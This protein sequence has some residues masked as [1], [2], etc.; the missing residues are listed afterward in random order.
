MKTS[1]LIQLMQASFFGCVLFL[2]SLGLEIHLY[3]YYSLI[4]IAC[5][6]GFYL[7]LG[8]KEN[9]IYIPR[10]I[11]WYSVFMFSLSSLLF[12]IIHADLLS[13]ARSILV[14][15]SFLLCFN[16]IKNNIK[17]T[18]YFMIFSTLFA[19]IAYGLHF[20]NGHFI[21]WEYQHL[22]NASLFFDPNYAST[23]F[24]L[25]AILSLCFLKN[26][27]RR[28][29]ATIF[30]LFALFFT[31]SKGGML[32]FLLGL[33][34]YFFLKYSYKIIIIIPLCF[35][36]FL[37]IFF[38]GIIDLDMFRFEQGLNSRDVYLN[39]TVDHVFKDM[40]IFGSGGEKIKELI[41]QQG[42]D[43]ISTHNYYLDLLITNGI[44]PFFFLIPVI[45]YT[46]IKGLI[47]RNIY[48]PSVISLLVSSMSISISIGGI[49]ILSFLYTYFICQILYG[50]KK[51]I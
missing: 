24:A 48:I 50:N 13:S 19:T 3:S 40:N 36:F 34:I 33:A 2:Y 5:F 30:F 21:F 41:A 6:T 22:R 10:G 43:N 7:F 37:Y 45:I 25:N 16:L 1:S 42:K 38:Q 12:S 31:Y 4:S 27:V 32:A 15:F 18:K 9:K 23:I 35:L 49:G 17:P 28:S 47:D 29:I 39:M 14:L 8:I 46:I 44:V 51:E 26:I 11:V 20:F